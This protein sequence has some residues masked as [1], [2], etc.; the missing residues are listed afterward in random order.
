MTRGGHGVVGY[1]YTPD[2]LEKMSHNAKEMWD[3]IKADPERYAQEC[4]R[5][6]DGL[7]GKPYLIDRNLVNTLRLVQ[8]NVIRFLGNIIQTKLKL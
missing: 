4:K 6:S 3:K 8:E 7:K 1:A 5:R 2:V